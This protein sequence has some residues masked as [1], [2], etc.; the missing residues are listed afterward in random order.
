[1]VTNEECIETKPEHSNLLRVFK[2]FV[3]STLCVSLGLQGKA[4]KKDL[5]A[6]SSISYWP[7]GPPQ[8]TKWTTKSR[9]IN[10]QQHEV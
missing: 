7:V 10:Q 1:M 5:Q 2:P 9:K 8:F 4:D 3:I 6:Y